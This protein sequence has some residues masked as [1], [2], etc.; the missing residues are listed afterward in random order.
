[1]GLFGM[2]LIPLFSRIL[3]I[4]RRMLSASIV[5]FCFIGSFS[6]NLNPVDLYTMVGF[7]VL[8]WGMHKF[9]FSQAALCIALILGPMLESNLRRGLLQSGD[10]VVEFLSGPI[11]LLFLALTVLSLGWPMIA[12][13]LAR[14]GGVHSNIV[15]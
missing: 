15:E 4:P 3:M 1:M 9:G 10:N 5:I 12:R 11:T 13:L 2:A 6:I 8:G 14:K 7:G